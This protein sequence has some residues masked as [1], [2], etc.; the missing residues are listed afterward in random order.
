MCRDQVPTATGAPFG[1]RLYH[2]DSQLW[3]RCQ[4]LICSWALE[5]G[6]C[7]DLWAPGCLVST[8]PATQEAMG[9]GFV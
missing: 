3:L 5:K 6:Y 8:G 9:R 7:P 4:A 2:G 1:R